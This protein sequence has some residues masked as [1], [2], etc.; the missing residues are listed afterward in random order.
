MRW[1]HLASVRYVCRAK[2][3]SQLTPVRLRP[4]ASLIFAVSS[5]PSTPGCDIISPRCSKIRCCNL[6]MSNADNTAC[7]GRCRLLRKLQ[8]HR[9]C[10]TIGRD[11][12]LYRQNG[13]HPEEHQ[14]MQVREALVANKLARLLA[15]FLPLEGFIMTLAHF[16]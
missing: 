2:Q 9:I 1:C 6:V 12:I 13:L 4:G 16:G 8:P 7:W 15:S 3:S 14:R 5:I 11:Q 10:P